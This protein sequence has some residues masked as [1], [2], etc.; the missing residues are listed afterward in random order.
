MVFDCEFCGSTFTTK[1]NLTAHINNARYCLAMR[2][3]PTIC[4]GC[5]KT[6]SSKKALT[7]HVKI[8]REIVIK[9][10]RGE[11]SELREELSKAREEIIRLSTLEKEYFAIRD[12]PHITTT[13]NNSTITKL[14]TI[15][16]STITPFTLENVRERLQN[17]E[18]TYD[19]FIC[20][21]VGIKKFILSL[22]VK[23]DEK[24]YATTDISR[25]NFHRLEESRQWVGDKGARFLSQ[26]FDEIA[27]IAQK[28]SD[29]LAAEN[30]VAV[31]QNNGSEISRLDTVRT[32]VKPVYYGLLEPESKERSTLLADVIK[33]IRPHVAV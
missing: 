24:N 21:L 31:K 20:G 19:Q 23:D 14:K 12:K 15:N 16:I 18:Y 22:V 10:L 7:A 30:T 25:P 27:P 13:Y 8:C 26:V 6:F 2:K 9:T 11:V 3:T 1:G 32:R 33:H 17:G 29:K 5:E 4:E 28:Y